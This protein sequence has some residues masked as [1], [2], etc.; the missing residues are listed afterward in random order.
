MIDFQTTII[1]GTANFRV[2]ATPACKVKPRCDGYDRIYPRLL[3]DE[4]SQ[5]RSIWEQS[6]R[7]RWMFVSK[8][9]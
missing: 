6:K 5:N 1:A 3:M 8:K 9:K 4:L 2:R 7:Q